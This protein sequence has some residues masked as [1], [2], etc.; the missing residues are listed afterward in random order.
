MADQITI[1]SKRRLQ[2]RLGVLGREDL[3]AVS[4][5]ICLQLG[6]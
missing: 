3:E 6:L 5:A 1:A 2:R 4:R